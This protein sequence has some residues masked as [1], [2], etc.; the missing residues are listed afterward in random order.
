MRDFEDILIPPLVLFL[1]KIY[2]G[3]K[4]GVAFDQCLKILDDS[5]Y[6]IAKSLRLEEWE[7]TR[8]YI[9]ETQTLRN[10][11]CQPIYGQHPTESECE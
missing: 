11:Y 9:K 1:K 10:K 8:N 3:K 2:Q 6:E 7:Q 5:W 4:G